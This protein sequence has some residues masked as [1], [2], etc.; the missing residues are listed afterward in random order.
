MIPPELVLVFEIVVL[1]FSVIIHEVAHGSVAY[2]MGDPTAKEQGRLT[3]NPISHIDLVGS[4]IVPLVLLIPA[5][6]GQPTILF[7]WA[8][9][10]PVNPRNFSDKRWGELKVALAGPA[11]NLGL[12]L[13]FGLLIRFLG[14]PVE[15]SFTQ[16]F[17][18]I[19]VLNLSLGIFN[20]I[21]IPPLDG[22]HILFGLFPLH[23]QRIAM[24]LQQY[25][26]FLLII[27]IF[28]GALTFLSSIIY[29][30]SYLITGIPLG[31]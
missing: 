4:I 11:T 18:I 13:F 22:S 15:S 25:G 12:A 8:K 31:L 29:G 16:L 10:V 1:I 9:P 20:L 7:G 6:F 27:L 19:V 17:G 24:L 5:L 30:L 23:S 2:S 3:L 21:P 14:M 26:M 28:S